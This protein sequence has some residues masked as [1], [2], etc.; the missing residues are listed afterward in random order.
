MVGHWC[1]IV[2]SDVWGEAATSAFW[3]QYS[4]GL[5]TLLLWLT[6]APASRPLRNFASGAA[7]VGQYYS[8]LALSSRVRT[9]AYP[10]PAALAGST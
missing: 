3:T 7:V 5:T 10:R 6:S 2:E 1:E 4:P 8:A 9:V